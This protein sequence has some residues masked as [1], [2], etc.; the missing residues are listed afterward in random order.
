MISRT[1]A[2]KE[3]GRL[4]ATHFFPGKNQQAL[5]ELI[6][7]LQLGSKSNEHA[8]LVINEAL[9]TSQACPTPADLKKL[10]T[11]VGRKSTGWPEP[12]ERCKESGNWRM[13]NVMRKGLEVW[14]TMRC[15]CARGRLLWDRENAER[16]ADQRDELHVPAGVSIIDPRDKDLADVYGLPM[17]D[18]GSD[19]L[20]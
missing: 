7:A 8:T 16:R 17:Y 1:H 18:E 6:D 5:S 14:A 11:E 4:A 12:C 10:C 19:V 15:S 9:D 13:V 3:I 2:K 20:R